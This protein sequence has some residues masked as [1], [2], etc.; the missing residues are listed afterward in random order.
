MFDELFWRRD[1][2]LKV[3][4]RA[5]NERWQLSW[6]SEDG[7]NDNEVEEVSLFS[8]YIDYFE[9]V[10]PLASYMFQ[11]PQQ[12]RLRRYNTL[13]WYSEQDSASDL[14]RV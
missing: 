3:T 8:A 1:N 7:W 13:K 6:T 10:R 12:K 9:H 14:Q 4:A 2:S 11:E 5:F